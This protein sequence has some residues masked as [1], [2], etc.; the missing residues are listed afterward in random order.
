MYLVKTPRLVQSLLP[1][2]TWSIDTRDHVL[3]LTFD[4]GPVP[5]V[6]SWVLEQLR[7]FDA[8]ATF[9]CVGENIERHPE[10]FQK[11]LDDGHAVGNHTY[12]HL[13]AWKSENLTYLLNI[14]RCARLVSSKLFRPPYGKLLPHQARTL[15]RHY[16]VVM[17][18]VLSGDFDRQ[19][20]PQNCLDNVIRHARQGSIIVFH[21]ST[22]AWDR[23]NYALPRVLE[24][25]SRLGYKF[26]SLLERNAGRP[27]STTPDEN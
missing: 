4:D 11:I 18:D 22:K 12:S 15:L 26:R 27:L 5:Q 1:A 24:H 23:L 17:W 3:F 13:D 16:E 2:Y 21:D 7:Q 10:L 19:L 6:T 25:F 8:K 9:F 20:T 14:R